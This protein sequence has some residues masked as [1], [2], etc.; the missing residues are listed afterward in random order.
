M[1]TAQIAIS[2]FGQVPEQIF[3][4]PHPSRIPRKEIYL[5]TVITISKS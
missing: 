5:D 3:D 2:E 1:R 4:K